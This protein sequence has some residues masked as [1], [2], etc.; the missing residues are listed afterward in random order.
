MWALHSCDNKAC[1]N[2][3]HIYEGTPSQNSLDRWT[4]S[5]PRVGRQWE[6]QTHTWRALLSETVMEFV[7]DPIIRRIAMRDDSLR[8][9]ILYRTDAPDAAVKSQKVR[10]HRDRMSAHVARV[11]PNLLRRPARGN[12]PLFRKRL[13]HWLSR[14]YHAPR[15]ATYY[16][17]DPHPALLAEVAALCG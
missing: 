17:L 11:A 9:F 2:P 8:S 1:V 6:G 3:R 15:V 12:Q 14:I 10:G 16:V 13:P 5:T 4:R 7:T